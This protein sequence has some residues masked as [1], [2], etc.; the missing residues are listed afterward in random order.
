[1]LHELAAVRRSLGLPLAPTCSREDTRRDRNTPAAFLRGRHCHLHPQATTPSPSSLEDHAHPM[2]HRRARWRSGSPLLWGLQDGMKCLRQHQSDVGASLML[3][4]VSSLL[5]SAHP[6]TLPCEGA[7]MVER[8]IKEVGKSFILHEG[9]RI[10]W[11]SLY[12]SQG[13]FWA[14]EI[15]AINH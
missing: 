13:I 10:L 6:S 5:K 3:P 12:I 11:S 4:L 7:V 15:T 9:V 1:L 8:E 14:R 2:L